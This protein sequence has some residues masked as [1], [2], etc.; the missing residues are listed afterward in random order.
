MSAGAAGRC[1]WRRTRRAPLS[2]ALGPYRF[3][4]VPGEARAF[5]FPTWLDPAAL[6]TALATHSARSGDVYARLAD[7]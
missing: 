7:A 6:L 5:A 1:R 2:A 4:F 3:N